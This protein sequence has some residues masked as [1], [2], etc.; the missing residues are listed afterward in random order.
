[1][2]RPEDLADTIA[3]TAL[4]AFR[5]A[6]DGGNEAAAW[7]AVGVQVAALFEHVGWRCA[8]ADMFGAAPHMLNAEA[9]PARALC[10]DRPVFVVKGGQHAL[11]M[12][13]A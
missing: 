11:P 2:I 7:D 8:G 9:C 6:Y 3:E 13:A 4:H 10:P 5:D 1:V 12:D